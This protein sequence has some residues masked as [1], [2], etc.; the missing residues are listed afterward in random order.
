VRP[1]EGGKTEIEWSSDFDPGPV[2][3]EEAVA[4]VE[5]THRDVFI[6]N[7]RSTLLAPSTA[8]RE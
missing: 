4:Q 5:A 8:R 6:A 2:P 7:L 1:L 3:E